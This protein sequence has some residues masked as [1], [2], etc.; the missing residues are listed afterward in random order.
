MIGAFAIKIYK[1][2]EHLAWEPFLFAK[3]AKMEKTLL[4]H[5]SMRY[6]ESKDVSFFNSLL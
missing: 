6:N 5:D 4:F 2:F 3:M 1:A